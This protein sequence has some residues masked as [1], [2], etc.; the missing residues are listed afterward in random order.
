M[1]RR[2]LAAEHVTMVLSGIFAGCGDFLVRLLT[3]VRTRGRAA[4][5]AEVIQTT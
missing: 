1:L 3:H 5:L 2:R 4:H